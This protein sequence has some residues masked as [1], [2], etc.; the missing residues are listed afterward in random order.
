M[1]RRRSAPESQQSCQEARSPCQIRKLTRCS[2]APGSESPQ[3][4]KEE[5]EREISVT[6][7]PEGIISLRP[8]F[9]RMIG[10]SP[11]TV[12]DSTDLPYLN[13]FISKMP[14][15][16][17]YAVVFP[18]FIP[19]LM[20]VAASAASLRHSLISLSAVVA[21]TSLQRPLVRALLHHQVTL[22][23]VQDLLSLGRGTDEATI[24]TVMMLAYFNLFSGRFLSA[25]RH[26]QG[27]SLLLQ[28]YSAAGKLPSPTTML[29]WRCAVRL[30][31]FLS[32][33]YPCK[34]IFPTPP[35]EQEDLHRTWI[36]T[37]VTSTGEEWALAQFA[38]DNLQS[39]AA[40]LS[41]LAYQSRRIGIPTEDEIQIQ[42]TKLLDDFSTWRRRKIFLEQDALDEINEQYCPST[43]NSEQ[44]LNYPPMKCPNSF[45]ANLLNEYRCAVMFVT[46]IASP[47]IGQSYPFDTVRKIHAVDSCRSISATGVGTF[48]VS[49]IRILQLV[50]LV[51]SD[52]IK[53]PDECAWIEQQLDRVSNR[54]VQAATR[55]NEMLQIVWGSTYPWTYVETEQVMQNADDLE[56][57]TLEEEFQ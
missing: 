18:G 33:V 5:D 27:V 55:V 28:Q 32:S 22:R 54:G 13:Y 57:L 45:Y 16:H 23:Q 21:D 3:N 56:Q 52:P 12:I 19:D 25:R 48:P 36:R 24:Y 31:Y 39:R 29:I 30:D 38:L 51:F 44:F 7:S 15:V 17:P 47:R 8:T 4:E 49:V 46:F 2:S 6:E 34:P 11:D 1:T 50:G 26:V 53:F 43:T 20:Q 35:P 42:C 10:P 40:H 37:A 14:K 41:W 9:P